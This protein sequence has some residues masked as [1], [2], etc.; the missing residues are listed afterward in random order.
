M[1]G[2]RA[3]DEKSNEITAIPELIRLL[4]VKGAVITI[5]AMGWRK[6]IAAQIKDQ[7]ADY[8]RALKGNQP[9][10]HPAV[11][12]LFREGWKT[13]SRGRSIRVA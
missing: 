7:G 5:D 3:V 10:P 13:T 12:E 1:P 9:T 2:Q 11:D 8:V 4:D 6:D